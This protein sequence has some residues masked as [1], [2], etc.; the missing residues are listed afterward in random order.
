LKVFGESGARFNLDYARRVL[1]HDEV[2]ERFRIV[3]RH[4][5][6]VAQLA[7]F[8]N[9]P[10]FRLLRYGVTIADVVLVTVAN[11]LL[12]ALCFFRFTFRYIFN[13]FIHF[14]PPKKNEGEGLR[15][16]QEALSV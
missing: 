10:A 11:G 4:R 14:L 13:K 2:G 15:R 7:V 6:D 5:N 16:F 12:L 8:Q 1:G 3:E 9:Y